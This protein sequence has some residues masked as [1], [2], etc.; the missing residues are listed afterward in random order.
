MAMSPLDAA[1]AIDRTMRTVT[2]ALK[3]GIRDAM[4]AVGKKARE[5]M[6]LVAPE[7]PGSD[8]KFS[9]TTKYNGGRLGVKVRYDYDDTGVRVSPQGPWGLPAGRG[10][11]KAGF[12]SWDKG[13]R[14]TK[15]TAE[16]DV[17][18]V[19]GDTVERGFRRG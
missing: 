3:T 11:S 17:P 7:V 6:M 10:R 13:E 4:L 5:E 18:K 2:A 14:A 1:G 8:R 19:I 9:G 12:G 15:S 16:R